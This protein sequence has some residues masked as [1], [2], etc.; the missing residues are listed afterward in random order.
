MANIPAGSP[1][2]HNSVRSRLYNLADKTMKKQPH[3]IYYKQPSI[4]QDDPFKT[5]KLEEKATKV[6]QD[7]FTRFDKA[8]RDKLQQILNKYRENEEPKNILDYVIPSSEV[9]AIAKKI[10][11]AGLAEL[12][13]D[14]LIIEAWE[15]VKKG[16]LKGIQYSS[17]ELNQLGVKINI[18][19]GNPDF[20][21]QLDAL[22]S[23]FSS[24][25]NNYITG[26]EKQYRDAVLSGLEKEK[27]L[28]QIYQDLDKEFKTG[29]T[30]AKRIAD[31]QI[32]EAARQSHYNTL[33]E[34][35]IEIFRDIAV[36][37]SKT[38]ELCIALQGRFYK[39]DTHG[40]G[41][42]NLDTGEF[43]V[44]EIAEISSDAGLGD[45]IDPTEGME[46]PQYHD[47]CRCTMQPVMTEEQYKGN[48]VG[49]TITEIE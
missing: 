22:K 30:E 17:I 2:H 43:L 13:T 31:N 34:N 3:L 36:V 11:D 8:I 29:L 40:R 16:Y 28:L 45:W 23:G 9:T 15:Y 1:G 21:K 48:L 10:L 27:S 42:R 26:I 19:M 33:Q 4:R 12:Q 32:I 47:Y 39:M 46:G 6:I 41:L 20:Q 18:N 7:A 14:D 38:C 49:R 35:G 5:K 25:L 24:K 44:D 37:D